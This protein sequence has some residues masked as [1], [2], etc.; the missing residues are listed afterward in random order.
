MPTSKKMLLDINQ[1]QIK[2]AQT[3]GE[4]A[5]ILHVDHFSLA[6]N[7]SCAL[8]GRSGAGKTSFLYAIAGLLT[9][10][11]GEISVN[12]IP[13]AQAKNK[14]AIILQDHGLLPWKT[15]WENVAL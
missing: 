11:C 3:T 5:T 7:Q 14:I 13:R 15:V 8:I 4:K 6:P 2:Y 10:A 9:P 1:L 12:Q